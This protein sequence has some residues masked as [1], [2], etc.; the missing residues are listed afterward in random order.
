MHGSSLEQ[1][2]LML[3]KLALP[4]GIKVLDVG[5]YSVNGC[6]KP[7]FYEDEYVG[8]DLRAGANVAVVM[9]TPYKLPF[10]AGAFDLVISGQTL[11]HVEQPWRL[12]K[13]MGRVVKAGGYIIII[14]PSAGPTHMAT[15]AWRILPD[16]MKGMADWAGLQVV[17][18]YIKEALP[19]NDCVAV[20][21]KRG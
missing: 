7:Y 11:E 14:A 10:E 5:S 15:D 8:C 3:T 2:A 6:Y 13:E 9:D 20:M 21:H 18:S 1:M 16:G 19:W 17:E 12:V 4:V